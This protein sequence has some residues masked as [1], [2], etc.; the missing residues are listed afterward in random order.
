MDLCLEGL[1]MTQV[2][3]KH[4]ALLTQYSIVSQHFIVV[5]DWHVLSRIFCEHFR[6]EDIKFKCN[7]DELIALLV[8][9]GSCFIK[10]Q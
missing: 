3:S 2:E 9:F 7:K 1:M 5:F 4:I 8:E 10:D 6:M